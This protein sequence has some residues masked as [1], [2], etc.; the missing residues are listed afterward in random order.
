MARSLNAI[1]YAQTP[2]GLKTSR[3]A[4]T[5]N[6]VTI[7]EVFRSNLAKLYSHISDFKQTKADTLF[8]SINLPTI[9]NEQLAH[10]ESPITELEVQNAIKTLKTHKRRGPDGFSASYYELFAPILTPILTRAFNSILN[11][12]TF[13]TE[14]L[15][16]I[17]TMLPKPRS[18]S[19]SCTNF[20]PISLPNLDIN[21]LAK[22][23]VNRLNPIIGRLIHCDQTGFMPTRQ[24]GDNI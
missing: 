2:I 11:G 8:A 20:R 17:I 23:I 14:T 18:D 4:Y 21:L 13:R 19:T 1:K 12:H 22:I 7:L 24:V 6:P 10:L 9:D 15:T 16:S 3:D 5:S